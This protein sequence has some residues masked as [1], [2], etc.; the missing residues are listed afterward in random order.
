MTTH[1]WWEKGT[2]ESPWLGH[3]DLIEGPGG[4]TPGRACH[5]HHWPA[6]Q[7]ASIH[8]RGAHALATQ[9]S[10][11]CRWLFFHVQ[12]QHRKG[13]NQEH[14][15]STPRKVRTLRQ[16][17]KVRR[18]SWHGRQGAQA[19]LRLV[20]PAASTFNVQT[21]LSAD[22]LESGHGRGQLGCLKSI[23]F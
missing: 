3:D 8:A 7:G 19:D 4:P 10:P 23:S 12:L 21:A 17:R 18:P 5:R 16:K 1:Y 9:A 6:A 13:N 2:S 15:T 11:L 14:R 20:L 22:A